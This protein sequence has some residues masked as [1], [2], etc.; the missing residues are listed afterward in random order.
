MKKSLY[1]ILG[2]SQDAKQEDIKKAY[3][4]LAR[5]YHPDINKNA[6]AEEKFKEINSAYEVLGDEKRRAKYDQVGDAVF[7]NQNFHDYSK[8]NSHVDINSIFEQIFKGGGG[9]PFGTNNF[10][11]NFGGFHGFSSGMEDLDIEVKLQIP[12]KTAIVGGTEKI[13][14]QNEE[15]EINIPRGIKDGEKLRLKGKGRSSRNSSGD[16]ILVISIAENR[17]YEIS[18][19]DLIKNIDISF[20]IALFG[21]KIQIDT[22]LGNKDINIP[23]G[24][25]NGQKLRI[26]EGGFYNRKSGEMG[27]LYLKVNILMPKI[28]DFSNDLVEK[29]KKELK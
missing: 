7:G 26:K 8:A 21:G 9:N 29:L 20:K 22:I 5:Q 16:L 23:A 1:E 3:R 28:E 4:K 15:R 24:I 17:E 10:N 12:I 2:V 19:D 6:G 14:I 25:K 18:G 13:R 27:N 11:G